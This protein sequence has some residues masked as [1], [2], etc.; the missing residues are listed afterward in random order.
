MISKLINLD[1]RWSII[2]A[3]LL[4]L[5]AI[6][7]LFCIIS[8]QKPPLID[9]SLLESTTPVK[10][11]NLCGPFSLFIACNRLGEQHSFKK[12][13]DGLNITVQG[14]SFG[15]LASYSK[16]IGLNPKL[17]RLT[18]EDLQMVNTTAILWVDGNHFVATDVRESDPKGPAG[19]RIY[20]H[21]IPAKWYSKQDLL[22]RWTGES[23]VLRKEQTPLIAN[24]DNPKIQINTFVQDCGFSKPEKTEKFLYNVKNVGQEPLNIAVTQTGCGCASAVV[25]PNVIEPKSEGAITL[26]V[27]LKEKRGLFSTF[28]HVETNDPQMPQFTLIASGGVYQPEITSLDKIYFGELHRG[29]EINKTFFI[30]DRGDKTLKILSD[31]ISIEN[32]SM[33]DFI[34]CNSNIEKLNADNIPQNPSSRMKFKKD[35]FVYT[36][37][38]KVQPDAPLGAF[39]GKVII[40]TNQPGEFQTAFVFFKGEIRAD[41]YTQPSTVLLS[42]NKPSVLISV[43]NVNGQPVNV[44]SAYS[45][46][47]DLKIIKNTDKKETSYK[48]L[49]ANGTEKVINGK[50]TFT[51]DTG[52]NIEVPVII[53]PS[54]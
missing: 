22:Q 40:N 32:E 26:S 21:G 50:V 3:L 14:V 9:I 42:K 31:N 19:I 29:K 41:Y 13:S 27:D 24:T 38:L 34:V 39:E 5:I 20:E 45:T 49:S 17:T 15:D 52:A 48:L 36:L 25:E 2:L 37:N 12:I 44:E 23:L 10:E 1:K 16:S 18:W 51:T 47:N 54:G 6:I 35:D 53:L 8:L 7:S 46:I 30:H 28:A 4:M 33:K 11:E 43:C